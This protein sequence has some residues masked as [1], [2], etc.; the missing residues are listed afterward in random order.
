MVDPNSRILPVGLNIK[1]Q[2][3]ERLARE[4]A[5][6]TGETVTRAILVAVQERLDQVRQGDGMSAEARADRIRR[7]ARDAAPR[8]VEPYRTADHGDLLYDQRGLPR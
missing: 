7:I 4:L 1:N 3:A 6:A 8:W 2:E 5:Q